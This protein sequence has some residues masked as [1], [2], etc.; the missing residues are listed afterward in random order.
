[1]FPD[2]AGWPSDPRFLPRRDI[3]IQRRGSPIPYYHFH[4]RGAGF[5]FFDEE[6][7]V[8]RDA[9]QAHAQ[10]CWLAR[11]TLLDAIEE[12][13]A[14]RDARVEVT[15]RAG[16]TLFIVPVA[17]SIPSAAR[18]TL[19]RLAASARRRSEAQGH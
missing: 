6:G 1:M 4:V 8:C 2:A 19:A 7:A 17:M 18:S 13:R 16:A 3:P 9:V 15:D 11:E 12:D 14:P 10:A 5:D